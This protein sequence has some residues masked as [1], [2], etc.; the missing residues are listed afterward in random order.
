MSVQEAA[1]GERSFEALRNQL[2]DFLQR[3]QGEDV[4]LVLATLHRIHAL[5]EEAAMPLFWAQTNP[6]LAAEVIGIKASRAAAAVAKDEKELVHLATEYPSRIVVPVTMALLFTFCAP[7]PTAPRPEATKSPVGHFTPE[8]TLNRRALEGLPTHTPPIPA[9]TLTPTETSTPA[10]ATAPATREPTPTPQPNVLRSL[11]EGEPAPYGIQVVLN[12]GNK[13]VD[14]KYLTYGTDINVFS[15]FKSAYYDGNDVIVVVNFYNKQDNKFY[16]DRKVR[17]VGGKGKPLFY[18]G[19]QFLNGTG[20][21][22]LYI[23]T[24]IAIGFK[25]TNQFSIFN[26]S[27]DQPAVAAAGA[28]FANQIPIEPPTE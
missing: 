13:Y 22:S 12:P 27:S 15:I 7:G 14:R 21:E 25:D 4:P 23:G 18:G 24:V 5:A 19:G 17:F 11:S 6:G 2:G 9:P 10:P 1:T 20:I 16:P 3:E 8:P 28:F 26:S